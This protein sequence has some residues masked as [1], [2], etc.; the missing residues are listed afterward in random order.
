M[1]LIMIIWLFLSNMITWVRNLLRVGPLTL[2]FI[3][4]TL[5]SKAVTLGDRLTVTF[6]NKTV[7]P[8]AKCNVFDHIFIYF[9]HFGNL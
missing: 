6:L 8:I 4:V 9:T 3:T 1:P 2:Y 5:V 7:F